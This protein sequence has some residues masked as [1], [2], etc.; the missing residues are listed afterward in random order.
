[1]LEL[2]VREKPV[3]GSLLP[4][5]SALPSVGLGHRRLI[6]LVHGFNLSADAARKAYAVF[7]RNLDEAAP[8]THVLM[9]D[10]VGILWPGDAAWG[11]LSVASFPT[12]IRPARES[13][14]RLSDYL[15]T[16][17]G[18][19]GSPVEIFFVSH[20]LGNRVAMELLLRVASDV[21][22]HAVVRGSCLMAAAVPVGM[23]S[24]R[25][26]RA[27]SLARTVTL[28]S[29]ADWVLHYAFPLGETLA[30]EGWMPEAVGFRGHPSSAWTEAHPM[31][32]SD[33]K[34]YGHGDYWGGKEVPR[35]VA[36]LLDVALTHELPVHT[37]LRRDLPEKAGIPNRSLGP[38]ILPLARALA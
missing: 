29:A 22:S 2:S 23:M 4:Q 26:A 10:L 38:R 21:P 35:H 30:R 18:P 27:A 15:S 24:R 5:A 11:L 3:G 1:M 32:R 7:A 14:Q 28:Y 9:A 13:A 16:V 31:V 33:G 19:G 36:R 25:L 37:V 20:S 34:G 6:F 12:E 8:A 17:R